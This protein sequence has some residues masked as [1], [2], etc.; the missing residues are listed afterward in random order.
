MDSDA[1]ARLA[2][3]AL[4]LLIISGLLSLTVQ[5]QPYMLWADVIFGF[6]AFGL[7]LLGIYPT[8]Q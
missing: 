5:G 3:A 6:V 4:A 8:R 2:L 1:T 7:L